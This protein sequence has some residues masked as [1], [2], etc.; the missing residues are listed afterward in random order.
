MSPELAA[1]L[2]ALAVAALTVG[3]RNLRGP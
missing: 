2:C 3:W 1:L